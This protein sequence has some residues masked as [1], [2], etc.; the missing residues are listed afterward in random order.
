MGGDVGR[1][2]ACGNDKGTVAESNYRGGY[3][4]LWREKAGASQSRSALGAKVLLG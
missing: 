2:K 4:P 3:S 1:H